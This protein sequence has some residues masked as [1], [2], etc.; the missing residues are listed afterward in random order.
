MKAVFTIILSLAIAYPAWSAP[1]QENEWS[2]EL[3]NDSVEENMN[4]ASLE[5]LTLDS[6]EKDS[7]QNLTEEQRLEQEFNQAYQLSKP[8]KKKV[9]KNKITKKKLIAAAKKS[10]ARR[11]NQVNNPE[12][13]IRK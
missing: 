3:L 9:S 5:E 7:H 10:Q 12:L 13:F 8:F 6:W 11:P 1:H 2:A 4:E